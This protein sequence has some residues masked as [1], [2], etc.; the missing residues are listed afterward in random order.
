MLRFEELKKTHSIHVFPLKGPEYVWD[1]KCVVG[2]KPDLAV[3]SA[4]RECESQTVTSSTSTAAR[5]GV[6]KHGYP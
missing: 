2:E 1:L 6:Y 3:Q 4:G 5:K